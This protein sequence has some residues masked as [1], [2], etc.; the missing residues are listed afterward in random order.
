MPLSCELS[1][2]AAERGQGTPRPRLGGLHRPSATRAAAMGPRSLPP[3]CLGTAGGLFPT[4]ARGKCSGPPV[5]SGRVCC[6]PATCWGRPALRPAPRRPPAG[7]RGPSRCRRRQHSRPRPPRGHTSVEDEGLG[8]VTRARQQD[9]RPPTLKAG[10]APAGKRPRPQTPS[11]VGDES[12][13]GLLLLPGT[14]GARTRPEM[15]RQAAAR[16]PLT[17]RGQQRQLG[18]REATPARRGQQGR[19]RHVQLPRQAGRPG[20]EAPKALLSRGI[21]TTEFGVGGGK[22]APSSPRFPS[23]TRGPCGTW[24][25]GWGGTGDAGRRR[26]AQAQ[27][28]PSAS[29]ERWFVVKVGHW[30]PHGWPRPDPEACGLD[31]V[32]SGGVRLG[33]LALSRPRL[34][35]PRGRGSPCGFWSWRP[36]D[37]GQRDRDPQCA[38]N[39]VSDGAA[40]P[41]P[42]HATLDLPRTATILGPSPNPPQVPPAA[43]GHRPWGVT[44]PVAGGGGVHSHVEGAEPQVPVQAQDVIHFLFCQLEVEHLEP[45]R[46]VHGSRGDTA[47]R[48]PRGALCWAC[49]GHVPRHPSPPPAPRRTGTWLSGVLAAGGALGKMGCMLSVPQE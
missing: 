5:A 7:L 23:S 20:A 4:R 3:A 14:R 1:E 27:G 17:P 31:A 48:A 43:A 47:E 38:R 19:V 33:P 12:A 15:G 24:G 40:C 35:T 34:R 18:R 6:S 39:G 16:E 36:E 49:G 2:Q 25:R 10:G 42:W 44:V 46:N 8:A 32:P 26:A 29:P 28:T 13:S 11:P 45:K 41:V 9:S 37:K 22:A 30:C 21:L